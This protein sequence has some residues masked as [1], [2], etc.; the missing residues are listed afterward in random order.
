MCLDPR[1]HCWQCGYCFQDYPEGMAILGQCV[2]CWEDEQEELIWA[3]LEQQET[4]L[5]LPEAGG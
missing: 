4:V 1:H 2:D 5:E 3:E